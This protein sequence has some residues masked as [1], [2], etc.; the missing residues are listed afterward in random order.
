V[1]SSS[2]LSWRNYWVGSTAISHAYAT[3]PAVVVRNFR[4]LMR[5][6]GKR[7]I[8][9]IFARHAGKTEPGAR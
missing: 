3:M 5:A 4:A 9:P 7:V 8:V 6:L 1:I 2:R